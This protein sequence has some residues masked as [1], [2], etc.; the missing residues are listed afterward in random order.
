MKHMNKIKI[1]LI[2]NNL[3]LKIFYFLKLNIFLGSTIYILKNSRKRILNF[4]F[5]CY[6]TFKELIN[7]N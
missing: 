3:K 2:M 7:N 5:K 6:I 4:H 1:I